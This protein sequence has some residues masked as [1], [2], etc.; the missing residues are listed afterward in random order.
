MSNNKQGTDVHHPSVNI[1]WPKVKATRLRNV[2][3]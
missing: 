2:F 1:K 3:G